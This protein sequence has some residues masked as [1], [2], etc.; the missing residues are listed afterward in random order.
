MNPVNSKALDQIGDQYVY[1]HVP[2]VGKQPNKNATVVLEHQPKQPDCKLCPFSP[3]D[4]VYVKNFSGNPL[5]EKWDGPYQVLLNHL[6]R[7]LRKRVTNL[8]P[9]LSSQES[10]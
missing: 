3:G 4:T 8:S 1:D 9:L 5:E 7:G 6:Y 2:T 10:C